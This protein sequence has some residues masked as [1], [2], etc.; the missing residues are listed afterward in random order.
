MTTRKPRTKAAATT[1]V[2]PAAPASPAVPASF[3]AATTE[4]VKPRNPLDLRFQAA[5]AHVT[6]S[7]SPVSVLLAL[8][9]WAGHFAG[10]PGKQ[11]ELQ[12][13]AQ[14]QA[15]RLAEYAATLALARPDCPALPCVEPPA[16]DRRFAAAEWNH[17]PFNLMHQSFL[18]AEEW[19]QAATT[20]I[21]G[22]SAHHEQ[23]ISF[24][25]R[26]LL[27]VLS[28]G[29]YLPTNPLVLQRTFAAGGLNLLRGLNN[30]IED[31]V[32][33]ATGSPP[34]GAEAFLV[35]RDVAVTPGK[36]VLRTP[37]MELIQ[38]SPTTEKVRP[39]PVLIVPAWIM[40]YYILDLSPHNSLIKYLV[41]EGYTVFCI[42]WKNPGREEAALGMEDYLELGFFA[43]LDAI[44][45]IV[46]GSKVHAT[47]YCLGGTLL[48]IANAAM[49]RDGDARL[50]SMTLFCA[51]TDFTEPGELAL[52]IDEGEVS[53]LEAQ[54]QETGYLSAGQMAGA[55]Q[56]LRSYDLMWSR[57]VGEYLMG[58]RAPMNDLMA[59]NA[60]TTRMPA[61]MHS[62]YLRQLFLNDALSEGRYRVGGRPV[63][64]TDI[65]TPS[66]CVA[67][68]SDHVAPWR[69]VHKL[70]YLT[71]AE[72]HFVLTS[73]GHNA[74]IVS[75]PGRPHRY[76]QALE[77]PAGGNYIPPDEWLTLAPRHEGSWWPEWS[78]WL[79]AHSGSPVAPPP[80][81]A[82]DYPPLA[83]APGSYVL[84]K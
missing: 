77:R 18:L 51:Q 84:E 40:K 6:M 4:F 38:Y 60:D 3:P 78:T 59:W 70:H 19:W 67:T 65:H 9:D 79:A 75:E 45:A 54:M 2:V 55:F 33:L 16:R 66:F 32:G 27:D 68:F 76:F 5:V 42:S 69:S 73:G 62:E 12:R 21:S 36:V 58:E 15:R 63:S 50:A 71:T 39:E 26:Q 80:M 30:A 43:A 35:G 41:G 52:F 37:L 74:G 53:L 10:S 17:W 48:A 57:M 47:G 61:R 13:L 29:N 7:V 49:A 25:A 34:S 14:E 56:L 72:L 24:I 64:L 83:D 44:E 11:L 31:L 82:D 28:P 46:P 81:G 23:V 20:G 1:A 8:V 22:V